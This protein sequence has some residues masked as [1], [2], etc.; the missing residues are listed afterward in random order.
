MSA[1]LSARDGRD[2]SIVTIRNTPPEGVSL[3]EARRFVQVLGKDGGQTWFR[4]IDPLKKRPAGPDHQGREGSAWL[5]QKSADGF[6]LYVVI[7]DAAEATGSG[8][9]VKDTDVTGCGVLFAEWD[10]GAPIDEQATRWQLLG[11]PEPT[12]QVS[13]GGKSVHAYWR[14]TEP[15]PPD[16][17]RPLQQR[18]I[19]HVNGDPQCKNPAR[20][21]RLPGSIYFDKR[22]GEATGVCRIIS[23][24][25]GAYSPVEIETCLRPPAAQKP[26]P[27]PV[28]NDWNPRGID[29]INQAA[30][31]IPRR[32]GG[33]GTYDH[34]RNA[35]CG[36]SAALAEAGVG[37]P[38]GAALALLSH[39]WPSEAAAAQVLSS[40]TTRE[41]ASFWA[42]AQEHGYSL[43][44][45][46]N[47]SDR[48]HLKAA[49]LHDKAGASQAAP[50]KERPSFE[51][52]WQALEDHAADIAG[53]HWPAMKAA[54]GLASK[55][56][57][58][59]LNRISTRQLE[60]LLEDAQRRQRNTSEPV[61][62]GGI[63]KIQPTPWAVDGVFRHGLNLLVGQAGAG[64]SRLASACIAAWLRGDR[65]W[66]QR[67]MPC[68]LPV[69]ERHALII[70]T[71]QG[72]EDW[73]LTLSPVGLVQRLSPTEMQLH[74]RVKLHALESGTALDSDG[75]AI[76][77]RWCDEH[78][79]GAVLI[80]S[81]AAVLPPGIDEDKSAVARP[82]HALQEALGTCWALLTHHTRKGAGKDGNLGVGAGRGSSAIDGAVS[83]VVG[84][85]LIHKMEGNILTPQESDPRRELLSTKR[86]GATLHLVISSD[87]NGYWTNEGSAED[88]KRQERQERQ[89]ANLTDAQ[90]DVLTA[91][92]DANGWLTGRQVAESLLTPGEQYDARG[93]RAATCRK[94]LK[95]LEV[96]GLIETK[97]V[98]LD[99]L[100]RASGSA[101]SHSSQS[102]ADEIDMGGSNGSNAAAQGI[103][104]A[105]PLAHTGSDWL[106][107]VPAVD[108]QAGVICEPPVRATCEPASEPLR[109][110]CE[111]VRAITRASQN[112]VVD[113][114]EPLEPV[115]G[116]HGDSAG[117]HPLS[118]TV[119]GEAGWQLPGGRI[120]QAGN[121]LVVDPDG[122]SHR[123]AASGVR[124][125]QPSSA[126]GMLSM[127]PEVQTD[128]L[129]SI[130]C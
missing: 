25:D 21:M 99:R 95:R 6:N 44:R 58:L 105:H 9:G 85:G 52:R 4:A 86:G 49:P 125:V 96:L 62:G 102:L 116:S 7:N 15:I 59:D 94:V 98:G 3:Q 30:N 17:W 37:D 66:L 108:L 39:L 41:A 69:E 48:D 51:Q 92:E 82:I 29:E 91:L 36:C 19:A 111:P 57:E 121:V 74:R 118:V 26:A 45:R 84:L 11:L 35:L 28:R 63:F 123:V 90:A 81:L 101:P 56:G 34:D 60:Q 122:Q 80:D 18:L 83:R 13:T 104:L 89:R 64:K 75:L 79:G 100:Y 24:S 97:R 71:D 31:H 77:R 47:G 72:L 126:D 115:D 127:S 14:L 128:L 38:D 73:A 88:L 32:I 93:T 27:L 67:E 78:P 10:D 103:S 16:E 42:I 46:E 76:I 124:L 113:C 87:G 12:A 65:S 61:S 68:D 114:L 1:P 117:S 50:V 107:P 22:T 55:A 40:A 130:T 70:G 119:E 8:G 110:T 129:S 33:E 23:T 109:A 120:P 20:V 106:S 43:K 53:R 2:Q 112:P 54:A 5:Q